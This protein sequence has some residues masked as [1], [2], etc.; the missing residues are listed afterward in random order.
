M[1]SD[2]ISSTWSACSLKV[3]DNMV[4][5]PLSSNMYILIL[6][7]LCTVCCILL[8]TFSSQSNGY[9]P[10]TGV[11]GGFVDLDCPLSRTFRSTGPKSGFP[12]N[13]C[14]PVPSIRQPIA[15]FPDRL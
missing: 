9:N 4:Q 6:P 8:S 12:H 14:H 13:G 2:E 7:T 10:C 15:S 3:S 11:P 5:S 1:S